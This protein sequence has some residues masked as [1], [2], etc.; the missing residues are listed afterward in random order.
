MPRATSVNDPNFK[1]QIGIYSYAST[2]QKS[3]AGQFEFDVSQFR[4]P[5][6]QKQF[7][8]RDICGIDAEVRDWVG[9]DRRVPVLIK[10]CRLLAEDLIRPKQT[11]VTNGVTQEKAPCQWLSISFK[12]FHG[13]WIAPAVAELVANALSDD[14]FT[15]TVYHSGTKQAAAVA[16]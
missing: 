6:G 16:R 1:P 14:G 8:G 2:A 4:D 5:Q 15:I 7:F 10:E 13:K 9:Q 12:D 3:L 11:G